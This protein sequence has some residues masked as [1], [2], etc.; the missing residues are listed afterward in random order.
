[1][2]DVTSGGR[3]LRVAPDP[4][5]FLRSEARNRSRGPTAWLLWLQG[6]EGHSSVSSFPR[7]LVEEGSPWQRSRTTCWRNQA[8]GK[9]DLL[10]SFQQPGLR[11]SG[12]AG[13]ETRSWCAVQL[14]A[15]AGDS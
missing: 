11:G 13:L 14:R 3:N 10:A 7:R 2:V 12:R 1:M 4:G 9:H 6:S 15:E 8:L 5:F